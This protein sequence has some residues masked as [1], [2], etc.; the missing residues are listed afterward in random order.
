MTEILRTKVKDLLC[1]EAGHEV[2]AK[3]WVRTKRGNKEI[4]F[5][6]LNDGSTIKNIQIV[7]DKNSE[8]A[9]ELPKIST[10][11]CIGVKGE[12]VESVG[13]GQSVEIR[14]KEITVYGECDPVR[15][16]LQKKDTSFEYLR[17]VAHLRPRTNTFGAVFRLRSQMAFA[18]HEYFHSKGFVYL[19]TPLG[20]CLLLLS[21]CLS[22]LLRLT[23]LLFLRRDLELRQHDIRFEQIGLCRDFQR[24]VLQFDKAL[25]DRKTKSGSFCIS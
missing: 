11:A 22:L 10:G 21:S 24:A 6:A 18:I 15:Y 17:T 23:P 9:E 12:L 1:S 3:G 4:A 25:G 7:V 8:A 2:L 19:H 16:P 14:A 13:S 5:I 20:V